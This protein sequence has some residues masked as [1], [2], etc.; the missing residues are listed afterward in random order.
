MYILFLLLWIFYKLYLFICRTVY[1]KD[2]RPGPNALSFRLWATSPFEKL[3]KFFFGFVCFNPSP[4]L[5]YW[6]IKR[7]QNMGV[8]N[9]L[10][11]LNI[12]F[13]ISYKP[14]EKKRF[15]SAISTDNWKDHYGQSYDVFL[16]QNILQY[17]FLQLQFLLIIKDNY[18]FCLSHFTS[19]IPI[20]R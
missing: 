10:T 6:N 12:S 2:F 16:V 11:Y 8:S 13:K 3:G 18:L 20:Q 17:L 5:N 4:V 19:E 1:N 14:R 15:S 7:M 9:Y